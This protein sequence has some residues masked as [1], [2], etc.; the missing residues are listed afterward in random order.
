MVLI[1][2]ATL[3]CA[4]AAPPD[5]AQTEERTSARGERANAQSLV[6]DAGTEARKPAPGADASISAKERTVDFERLEYV[7]TYGG[8]PAA[9]AGLVLRANGEATLRFDGNENGGTP[10]FP[11]I[12]RATKQ[13]TISTEQRAAIETAL[14]IA[15]IAEPINFA[16]TPGPIA[17]GDVKLVVNGKTVALYFPLYEPTPRFLPLRDALGA[18]IA[19]LLGAP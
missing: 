2:A 16:P 9:S 12:G 5:R 19:A 14:V 1:V 10:L 6:I 13:R 7:A 4:K 8:M 17:T 11:K 15:K 3:A 18:A